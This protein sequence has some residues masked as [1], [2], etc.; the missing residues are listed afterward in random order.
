MAK[1]N[2]L[3][4]ETREEL[5]RCFQLKI[6]RALAFNIGAGAKLI[7]LT[8]KSPAGR[9]FDRYTFFRCIT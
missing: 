8:L 6:R 9:S 5:D 3:Q 2:P 7:E 1:V 4:T